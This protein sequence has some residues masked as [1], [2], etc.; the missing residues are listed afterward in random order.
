[1]NDIICTN[2][3]L[4]DA[5]TNIDP[6]KISLNGAKIKDISFKNTL[7]YNKEDNLKNYMFENC[8]FIHCI[9]N[10]IE[11]N[12][13][14]FINCKFLQSTFIDVNIKNNIFIN[15]DFRDCNFTRLNLEKINITL[16][17]FKD[18]KYHK[19]K[20][21]ENIYISTSNFA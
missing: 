4:K 13:V 21:Q 10:T 11:I 14:S 15:C 16:C 2:I 20:S 8:T 9:F 3:K 17:N 19:I 12:S 1:M 5:I 18:N 7:S 6:N